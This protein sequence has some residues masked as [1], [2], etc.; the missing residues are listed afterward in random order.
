MGHSSVGIT[1]DIYSHVLPALSPTA[2]DAIEAVF[3]GEYG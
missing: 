1:L 3:G 2:A